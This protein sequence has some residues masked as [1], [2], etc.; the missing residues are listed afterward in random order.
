MR[1]GLPEIVGDDRSALQAFLRF[2]IFAG[3]FKSG[4]NAVGDLTGREIIQGDWVSRHILIVRHRSE[5][6]G[7][8]DLEER[9]AEIG[10]DPFQRVAA[11]LER[12]VDARHDGHRQKVIDLRVALPA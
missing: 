3:P 5:V 2:Q 10:L 7:R 1:T 4:E 6:I 11:E 9:H 12:Q 8:H